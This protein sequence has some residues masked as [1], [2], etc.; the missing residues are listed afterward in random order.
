MSFRAVPV[1]ADGPAPILGVNCKPPLHIGTARED[2][3]RDRRDRAREEPQPQPEPVPTMTMEEQE[4]NLVVEHLIPEENIPYQKA[5][6]ALRL[7]FRKQQIEAA[8]QKVT[9]VT[10]RQVEEPDRWFKPT[11]PGAQVS[12]WKADKWLCHLNCGLGTFNCNTGYIL[13]CG[14]GYHRRCI[15]RYVRIKW[16][17]EQ[18]RRENQGNKPIVAL[19]PYCGT[20]VSDL[21]RKKLVVGG[22]PDLMDAVGR[23]DLWGVRQLLTNGVKADW[24]LDFPEDGD[25]SGLISTVRFATSPGLRLAY[26]LGMFVAKP[27]GNEDED[28]KTT[29]VHVAAY[30]GDLNIIKSLCGTGPNQGAAS[31]KDND[32]LGFTPIAYAAARGHLDVVKFLAGFYDDKKVPATQAQSPTPLQHH[33]RRA[34][35]WEPEDND[36]RTPLMIAAAAGHVD[37][38]EWLIVDALADEYRTDNAQRSALF[39]AAAMGHLDVVM[40]LTEATAHIVAGRSGWG[41]SMRREYTIEQRD[42]MGDSPLSI[43]ATNGR[44]P[45]V[46]WLASRPSANLDQ[47]NKAGKTPLDLAEYYDHKEVAECLAKHAKLK[48]R[49]T[50]DRVTQKY[51]SDTKII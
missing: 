8:K 23:D 32:E 31:P 7:K 33:N 45:T 3:A 14:H 22:P 9:A 27:D 47:V 21:D 24:L 25:G 26:E 34:V 29:T 17:A 41:R 35:G 40:W 51:D 36:E 39:W 48:L 10:A 6:A 44:L 16:A 42:Y 4:Q 15:A 2:R 1:H 38:V 28:G 46:E 43:A 20:T 12:L 13:S 5:Q 50:L 18:E 37:V 49:T 11:D 30:R 19:C